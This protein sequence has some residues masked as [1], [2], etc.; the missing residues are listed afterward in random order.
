MAPLGPPCKLS[1]CVVAHTSFAGVRF[2][3]RVS[4]RLT[5]KAHSV[6]RG[7]TEPGFSRVARDAMMAQLRR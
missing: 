1:K 7:G 5:V 3:N 2:R 4:V 6:L